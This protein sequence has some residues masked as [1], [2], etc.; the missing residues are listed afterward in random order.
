MNKFGIYLILLNISVLTPKIYSLL[1]CLIIL[2]LYISIKIIINKK[3]NI[4][5]IVDN[6]I[7]SKEIEAAIKQAGGKLLTNIQIFD[8]YPSMFYTEA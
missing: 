3:E 8:L 2:P 1:P 5:I 7:T 4:I 6:K